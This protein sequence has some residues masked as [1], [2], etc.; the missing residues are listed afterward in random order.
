MRGHFFIV[1]E[2]AGATARYALQQIN[3]EEVTGGWRACPTGDSSMSLE[4]TCYLEYSG[5]GR[6]REKRRGYQNKI[7]AFKCSNFGGTKVGELVN[8]C[9][10]FQ[11]VMLKG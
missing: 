9:L 4:K 6:Y 2:E 7:E 10:R 8:I 5:K 11:Y 3:M 1:E